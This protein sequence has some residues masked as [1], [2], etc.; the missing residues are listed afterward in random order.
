MDAEMNSNENRLLWRNDVR[1]LYVAAACAFVTGCTTIAIHQIHIPSG[2]FDDSV[3][4]YKHN[5]YLWL[6]WIIL[7]HCLMVLLS[8]LGMALIVEKT[9]RA[10][11][12]LGFLLLALFVFSEWERTLGNLWH[13][14]GLR[15]KYVTT[16]DVDTLQFL[17]YEMQHR[18]Y[19]SNVHFLLFTMGFTLGN[20]SYGLALIT[21]KG[22]DRWLGASLLLWACCTSLAFAYDFYPATWIGNIVEACNKV[23]QPI[24][25]FVIGYWLLKKAGTM[26]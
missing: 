17:R 12:I 23:Y 3:Q 8:M 15:Q 18:L 10:L 13:L 7:F 19:Q 5:A 2:S 1:F 6:N 26:Q 4:L 14:N 25:R 16:T 11:A 20:A 24:I 9:S 22:T 21:R